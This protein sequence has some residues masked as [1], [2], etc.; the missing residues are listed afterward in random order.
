MTPFSRWKLSDFYTLSQTSLLKTTPFE[1]AQL[2]IWLVLACTV[3]GSTPLPPTPKLSSDV[4][5][6][7]SEKCLDKR[8]WKDYLSILCGKRCKDH[9]SSCIRC[10]LSL[11]SPL[12]SCYFGMSSEISHQEWIW[13]FC[14]HS[15]CQCWRHCCPLICIRTIVFKHYWNSL[16]TASECQHAC[17]DYFLSCTLSV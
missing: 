10:N 14:F 3:Y 2:T 13:S 1:V 16:L 9:D 15:Q 4:G 5:M 12:D 6:I 8:K 7:L 17:E 11:I